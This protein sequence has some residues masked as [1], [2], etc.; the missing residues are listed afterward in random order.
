MKTNSNLFNKVSPARVPR[1]VFDLSHSKILTADMG[2]LYPVLCEMMMPGDKFTL[3]Q[4]M[5]VRAMPLVSPVLHEINVFVHTFFVPF[6]ILWD[7]WE[8]FITG[9]K[10][11][12]DNSSIP[13]W[14]TY[15]AGPVGEGSLWDYC[16]FPTLT[17]V[18]TGAVP[19]EFLKRAYNRIWNE[20]YRDQ[21]LQDPVV[22]FHTNISSPGN[23]DILYRSWQKDYFTSAQPNQQRGIAPALP[24]SG[25]SSAVFSPSSFAISGFTDGATEVKVSKTVSDP[26]LTNTD[27]DA[28]FND[29]IRGALDNN[30]VD[31][32]SA[33]TFDVSDLRLAFQIQK[34]MERNQRCGVRYT[35]F[36]NAH[37]GVSPRD[38]RM[39]RPEFVGAIKVPVTISEVLQ[40][41]RSDAGETPQGTLAGHGISVGVDRV[42]TYHAKEF[43][44][45]MSL[46]SIM[47]KPAYQQGIPRQWLYSTRYEFPFPEFANLSEQAII[48]AEIYAN[49]TEADNTTIFGYQGRYDEHRYK[50]N[51]V[52]GLMR[53]DFAHWHL[54]RIF[55]SAPALNDDFLKCNPDTRIFAVEAEPGFVINIGNLIKAV[56]PIPIASNPG[57]IDHV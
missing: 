20:Y 46:L 24:I 50:P 55:G 19:H 18:P 3:S 40:T 1:S 52:H 10:D 7:G 27:V 2:K 45:M 28:D 33:T 37:F 44:I 54:G 35:E 43:G 15:G 30:E 11:G 56:R 26:R 47:P 34:W 36:L 41:S 9:G 21:T 53:S 12:T 17:G 8:E 4:E 42:G 5:I 38:E 31:L 25:L 13:R 39:Q 6:R 14:I 49:T 57:L 23:N 16:G 51:T 48:R 32:S 29:N 22:E